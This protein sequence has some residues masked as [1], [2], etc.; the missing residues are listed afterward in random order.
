LANKAALAITTAGF[1]DR[2]TITIS[3]G[4]TLTASVVTVT[5]AVTGFGVIKAGVV[6]NGTVTATGGALGI[7]GNLVGTGV[8]DIAASSNAVVNGALTV[9]STVFQSGTETLSLANALKATSVISGYGTGDVIDLTTTTA[10]KLIYAGTTTAGTLT[11]ENG[12]TVVAKLLFSGDYTSASFSLSATG[13]TALITGV[14]A[15][16]HALPDFGLS[17]GE[18]THADPIA[19][20]AHPASGWASLVEDTQSSL[21][22]SHHGF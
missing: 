16:A 1:V 5:G 12:S 7:T 8:L 3:T 17:I 22:L 19:S 2:G 4:S 18:A 10:T 11:V 21:L 14:S 9:K 20:T 15:G 13:S 6:D